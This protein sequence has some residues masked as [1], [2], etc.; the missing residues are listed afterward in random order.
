MR[1]GFHMSPF[2][3]TERKYFIMHDDDDD[4]DD[5][6]QYSEC[7]TYM[8]SEL[9]AACDLCIKENCEPQRCECCCHE[10]G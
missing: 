4:D 5:E 1:D 9:S 8:H 7:Y 6:E 3:K 10:E 2:Y